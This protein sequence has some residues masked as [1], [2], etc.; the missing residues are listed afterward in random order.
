MPGRDRSTHRIH[1]ATCRHCLVALA[2]LL[3]AADRAPAYVGP[4]TDV[5]FISYAMTL[6]M[7]V[8]AAFSSVLVWPLYVMLRWMRGRKNEPATATPPE[9]APEEAPVRDEG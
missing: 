3:L 2:V 7:W 5:T 9:A 4:G 1:A 6:L 8:L